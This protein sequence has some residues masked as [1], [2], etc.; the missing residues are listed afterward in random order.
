MGSSSTCH[1]LERVDFTG[2]QE[3]LSSTV[4]L[5]LGWTLRGTGALAVR[6]RRP[7]LEKA[8]DFGGTEVAKL[9]RLKRFVFEE[10]NRHPPQFED[11]V[12]NRVEHAA[13]LLVASFKKGDTVPGVGGALFDQFDLGRSGAGT[14]EDDPPLKLEDL[15]MAGLALDL[16]LIDLGDTFRS[17]G[18][19]LGKVPIVGEEEEA[20]ALEIETT[21]G[22]DLIPKGTQEIDDERALAGIGSTAEES[23]RLVEKEIDLLL[24]FEPRIDE[25]AVHLDMVAL[26]V[27]L[28][29]ELG[30]HL[31]IDCHG[32]S[33]DPLLRF[34][35]GGE[36]SGGDNLL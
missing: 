14:F 3:G 22:V 12:A 15:L 20:F 31:A 35:A 9:A 32:A 1:P 36:A 25:F 8:L 11:R 30:H 17:V 2:R 16:D 29:A 26:G 4:F 24:P 18:D 34:A 7:K 27:D 19:Q 13:D 28:R 33:D 5:A 23:L 21:D 6:E 10:A